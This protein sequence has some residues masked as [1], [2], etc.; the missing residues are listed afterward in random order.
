MMPTLLHYHHHFFAS[1][2]KFALAE[3]RVSY[4][5]DAPV[6]PLLGRLRRAVLL[7]LRK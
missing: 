4:F 1:P 7:E 3:E 6:P 5:G 2:N